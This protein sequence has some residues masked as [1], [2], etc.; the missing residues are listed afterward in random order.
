MIHLIYC[1][2]LLTMFHALSVH[3]HLS[4]LSSSPSSL[5]RHKTFLCKFI[6]LNFCYITLRTSKFDMKPLL[7]EISRAITLNLRPFFLYQK[8]YRTFT[9]AELGIWS[10]LMNILSIHQHCLKLIHLSNEII[11][12]FYTFPIKASSI[13]DSF[14]RLINV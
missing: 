4:Y 1:D 9:G 14:W 8:I 11:L 5:P 7:T 2:F 6:L 13:I 12:S 10:C 3:S